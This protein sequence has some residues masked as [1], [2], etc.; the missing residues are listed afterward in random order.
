MTSGCF[1]PGRD[2]VLAALCVLG[3]AP[4]AT[5]RQEPARV[6]EN[7]PTLNVTGR[8]PPP[9]VPLTSVPPGAVRPASGGET[10]LTLN[11]V[12]TNGKIWNPADNRYNDVRLRSYQGT[13]VDPDAPFVSPSIE[14]FPGDTVRLTLNNQLPVDPTCVAHGT[15]VNVPHC[16]NGTNLHTHGL[17][18]N[19]GGNGDNVLISVNPGVSFQYEYKLAPDHPAGTFWYHTHRHGSTALQVSSGM[20]G[21]LI[22]RGRR[23]PTPDAPGDIDTL[24][25]ATPLQ[26]F[27]E[28]MLVMQQIPY[29]CRE[30]SGAI[31][32]DPVD[33]KRYRCDP[34]DVGG[35]EG[36][37]QFGPS[38]WPDSGRHTTINGHVLPTFT[39]ARAG[40]IER[41]RVVHGGVRDTINLQFRQ[42]RSSAP[43]VV[44]LTAAD[45]DAYVAQN[46]SGDP[47]LQHLIAA[48]GL[49]LDA[50]VKT[51]VT[52]FQ[53]AYRWDLLLVFPAPG[54]YCVIDAAAPVPGVA[55]AAPSR[56]LLGFVTVGRGEPVPADVS[57]FLANKLVAAAGRL[58]PAAVRSKVMADL[59]D[60]LKLTSF[61]PHETIADAEVTGTQAM[62][63]NIDVTQTP[64]QFQVDGKPFDPARVD[65]TLTLGAVDEWTLGS[66][67]VSHPFHIHI[68]P[69]QIVKI[70]DPTG[71]D[72]SGRDAVDTFGTPDGSAD[73]QY[74]ALKGVWKDT[75][76]VKNVASPGQPGGKYT[77]VVRT[78]YKRY[79]GD[80]V[81]HCHILDHEDQGMMQYIR[82]ALPDGTGHEG[83]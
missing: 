51:D 76:W 68:N 23:L 1:S 50:V 71:K 4:A 31:K 58:M 38:S 29:A 6:V 33:G 54:T 17:W 46:C 56:Q 21:A 28:R 66:D 39:R 35:V 19:P 40:K 13:R 36:Y 59:R 60:G 26:P 47:L 45:Q 55:Q 67:F 20:A 42:L 82:I 10:S 11:V 2:A 34:G 37:D 15:D 62:T 7:P 30:A 79:I 12:Y 64:P 24:L 81:L 53:P 44:G 57:A 72:V 83:R 61:R 27:T 75:L 73:P 70:L 52:V 8:V 80:F 14:A 63:F 48:D 49:T 78:R 41:W 65:R 5:A 25:Q 16:F 77:V 3:A 22:V 69:F 74:R 18:V 43:G 32:V 9:A